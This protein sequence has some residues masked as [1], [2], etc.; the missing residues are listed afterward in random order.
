M[1]INISTNLTLILMIFICSGTPNLPLMK[2][3]LRLGVWGLPFS[4][5]GL[6]HLR[7]TPWAGRAGIFRAG[8]KR[9]VGFKPDPARHYGFGASRMT[10][11]NPA[12]TIITTC[13]VPPGGSHKPH[14]HN[15]IQCFSAF[16]THKISLAHRNPPP[17]FK[18][19]QF[20]LRVFRIHLCYLCTMEL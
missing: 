20:L 16:G 12:T 8:P 9:T 2:P 19:C 10:P 6:S 7:P 13:A 5:P 14:Y 17:P 18:P 4:E 15:L 3:R 11:P 1:K